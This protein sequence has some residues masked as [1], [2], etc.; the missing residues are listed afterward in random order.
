MLVSV[1]LPCY[2][3]A[4]TLAAMLDSLV[5]Q[6]F[7]GEWELLFVNNGST[8]NSVEIAM[9]YADRL[10]VRVVQAYIGHG[11]QGTVGHSYLVGF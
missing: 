10:P 2:N 8:D 5:A 7:K 1:V 6:T 4:S 11:P 3:G 9:S